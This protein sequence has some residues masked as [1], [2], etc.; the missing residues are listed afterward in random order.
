MYIL[1]IC[2]VIFLLLNSA[3][4]VQFFYCCF[5]SYCKGNINIYMKML[6]VVLFSSKIALGQHYL[7]YMK[8]YKCSKYLKGKIMHPIIF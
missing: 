8:L 3:I 7:S 6:I 4:F 5:V 2:V 1:Q